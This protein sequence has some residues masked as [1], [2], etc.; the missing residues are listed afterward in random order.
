MLAREVE[1]E[2]NR[3]FDPLDQFRCCLFKITALPD[4]LFEQNGLNNLLSSINWNNLAPLT[5]PVLPTEP[6]DFKRLAINYA[7]MRFK[8][9]GGINQEVLCNAMLTMAFKQLDKST[10]VTYIPDDVKGLIREFAV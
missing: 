4:H 7:E 2:L 1:E 5:L 9:K 8:P 6:F 3:K 10:T